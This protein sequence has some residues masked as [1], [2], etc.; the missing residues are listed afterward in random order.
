MSARVG[1]ISIIIRDDE[2]PRD[3]IYMLRCVYVCARALMCVIYYN[4]AIISRAQTQRVTFS[5]SDV[6]KEKRIA[7]VSSKG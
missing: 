4:N 5:R 3:G 2:M 7:R 1:V 6:R